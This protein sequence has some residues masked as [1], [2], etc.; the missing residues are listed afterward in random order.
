MSAAEFIQV[1][2]VGAVLVA[3]LAGACVLAA[4]AEARRYFPPQPGDIEARRFF[5]RIVLASPVWPLLI[6][7]AVGYVLR[8][9]VR[10]A[11]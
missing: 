9:L 8:T 6:L 3:F 2:L 4:N 11:R 10:W 7:A 1:W 5:A